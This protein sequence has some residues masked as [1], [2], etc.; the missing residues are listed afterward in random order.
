MDSW[1]LINI[2]DSNYNSFYSSNQLKYSNNYNSLFVNAK[3][4]NCLIQNCTY[5][6]KV[7]IIKEKNTKE[8]FYIGNH[9]HELN[10]VSY[11]DIIISRLNSIKN[12]SLY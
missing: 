7:V 3:L 4:Y 10:N 5:K 1:I 8:Y 6:F 9:N 12:K 2:P 11:R